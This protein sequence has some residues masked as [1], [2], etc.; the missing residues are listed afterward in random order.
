MKSFEK[1]SEDR[2][3]DRCEFSSSL[4]N[5]CISEKKYSHTL[6]VWNKFKMKSSSDYHNL[7]LKTNVLLAD[8]F[9]KFSNTCLEYY[10][11]DPC[12][13]FNSPGLS[14]DA[15]LKMAGIKLELIWDIDKHLF[16]EKRMR[17]GI[18]YI[19]QRCSKANN[20]YM[21]HY[22]SSE[23]SKF[24]LYLDA[25]NLHGL[26]MSNYL[27]Y[28]RFKW[29]NQK[30]TDKF[31]VNSIAENSSDGY[32]L[33]VDLEYPDELHELHND[34]PLAPEKLEISDDMLSKYCSDIAWEYEVKVSGVKKLVPNLGNKSKYVVHY[35]NLPLYLSVGMKLTKIHWILKFKQLDLLK[36]AL[37]VIQTKEKNAANS[38]EKQFFKQM[39]N[40]VYGKT[41]ENLRKKINVRLVNNA[42]GCKK[43]VSKPNFVSQTIFDKN[44]AAIHEIK[45]FLSLDKPIYY[46]GF[47]VLDLRKFKM[48]YFYYNYIKKKIDTKLLFTDTDSLTY[49]IKTDNVY[50]D[51]YEDKY[52]LDFSNYPKD[53]KFHDPSSLNEIG[54][55]K[56]ESKGKINDEFCWIKV[57]IALLFN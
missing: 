2:L 14:W 8:I 39:I 30:E 1:F 17:G 35:R 43:Y 26:G 10:G 21:T 40:S 44:V 4:K 5:K 50:E 28:G 36:D 13:Y 7:Y 52:L 20:K 48:Y 55:M 18:S 32:I 25:N 57:K 19:A 53:S 34:Y 51:F 54:K 11:L 33:E 27:A 42:K 6:N 49:E 38:F 24:I 16:I 22:D 56:D 31:D 29:L 12:H 23:E 37:I 46:V 41:M 45:P 3:P 15:M 9:K 47:N